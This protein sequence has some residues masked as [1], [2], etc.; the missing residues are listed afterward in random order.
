MVEVRISVTHNNNNNNNNHI[1]RQKVE[2]GFWFGGTWL[3]YRK[4]YLFMGVGGDSE[5]TE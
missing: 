1:K 3:V 4:E 2:R 5:R